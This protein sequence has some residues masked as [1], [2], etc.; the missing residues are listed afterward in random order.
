MGLP[1]L[2][3]KSKMFDLLQYYFNISLSEKRNHVFVIANCNFWWP[4]QDRVKYV[5]FLS[6]WKKCVYISYTVYYL[7]A[8]CVFSAI[9]IYLLWLYIHLTVVSNS[10]SEVYAHSLSTLTFPLSSS[11]KF[12]YRQVNPW[13]YSIYQCIFCSPAWGAYQKFLHD[14]PCL[15]HS[16]WKGCYGLFLCLAVIAGVLSKAWGLAK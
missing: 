5:V 8:Y 13:F 11:A 16:I 6:V 7:W 10:S 1:M 9:N 3:I 12:C 15:L 2:E 14:F 4:W